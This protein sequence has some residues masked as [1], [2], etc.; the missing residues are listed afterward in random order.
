MLIKKLI[1][2]LS[3]ISFFV[4]LAMIFLGIH[5]G[6][7]SSVEFSLSRRDKMN[8]ISTKHPTYY[9]DIQ[10]QIDSVKN[11]LSAKKIKLETAA[12]VIW[13]EPT[14]SVLNKLRASGGFFYHDSF[15]IGDSMFRKIILDSGMVVLGSLKAHPQI[16]PYKLY[17][18]LSEWLYNTEFKRD[19]SR[20]IVQITKANGEI[21]VAY[22]IHSIFQSSDD[23]MK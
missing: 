16:A 17:P 4:F 5:W 10:S 7:F 11:Y 12:T 3:F 22:P 9:P 6:V 23:T 19:S 1:F 13:D 21:E 14:Y 18:A 2:L 20:V 15:S 8:F